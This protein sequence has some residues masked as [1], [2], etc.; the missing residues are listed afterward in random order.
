AGGGGCGEGGRGRGEGGGGGSNR[1]VLGP[2]G[3]VKYTRTSA[4]RNAAARAEPEGLIDP[5]LRTLS[6][7]D[8]DTP[9]AVLMYYA[10]HP[11]SYYG[12]GGVSSDFRGLARQKRQEGLPPAPPVYVHGRR[13]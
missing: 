9:L 1:R 2:D 12:Q 4:T 5:W 7:W 8:G 6:F 13:R 11:M 3:K 10:T